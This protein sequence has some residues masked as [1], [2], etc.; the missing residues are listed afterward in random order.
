M[1]FLGSGSDLFTVWLAAGRELKRRPRSLARVE[2]FVP[3]P[4]QDQSQPLDSHGRTRAK[5][6]PCVKRGRAISS[7]ARAS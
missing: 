4:S 6:E 1:S 3:P 5:I 2:E 7:G